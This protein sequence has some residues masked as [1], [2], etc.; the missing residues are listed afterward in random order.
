[1]LNRS[2][3]DTKQSFWNSLARFTVLSIP[4]FLL[5]FS[6]IFSRLDRGLYDRALRFNIAVRP[7]PLNPR[8]IRVDLNDSSERELEEAINSRAAFADLVSV[9]ADCGTD[10]AF[11]FVFRGKSPHD[12]AIAAASQWMNHFVLA[13]VPV[14]K[15]NGSLAYTNMSED[16]TRLLQKQLWHIKEDGKGTIPEAAGFILPSREITEAAILGHIGVEHD[17]DGLYR[18][19]PLFY[20]W[21][22]GLVPAFA[23]AMAAAELGIDPAD[24]E[25]Y[26]GKEL[27]L[28]SDP[29]IRIPV[30]SSAYVM[31]PYTA[32]WANDSYRLSFAR[33]TSAVH[34]EAV[35]DE[36]SQELTGAIVLVAD[37]TTAKKDYGITPF[38]TLYPLSGIHASL[39]SGILN[40]YFY[41]PPSRVLQAS[42]LISAFLAAFFFCLLKKDFFFH[43]SFLTLLVCCF[44]LAALLWT[45]ARIVPCISLVLVFITFQWAL[46]FVI[47]LA[48]RYH[49][50]FL[51]ELSFSRY[52]SPVVIGELIKDPSKLSLGGEEREMSALFTDI[53][54]FSTISEKIGDP[55]RLVDL[56]NFYLGTMS[57]IVLDN[58]GTIDKYEG[59]AIIAFFGAPLATGRD[60]ADACR[61]AILIK[62]REKTLNEEI[63]RRNLSPL[64]LFTRAGVNSGKMVVG[65]MGTE[66]K[67]DYT[68]MGNAVNLAS[69]LEGINKQYHT[70][71]LIGEQTRSRIGDDFVLR[72]L[73]RVRAIG[74]DTPVR[75]YELLDLHGDAAPPL[76]EMIA[77]W[78][79]AIGAFE[80]E[81]FEKGRKLFASI[82]GLNP[83]D[84]TAA[85]YA[86]RCESFIKNPP[87]RG[88]DAI[89][90][91]TEK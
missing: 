29:P 41:V 32:S 17:D 47:R 38:E 35:F 23:L 44:V 46:H 7:V 66:K 90:N 67:M 14:P 18:R 51:L 9:L 82:C 11:D 80:T 26:P 73:D 42:I 69:R 54:G 20:R 1:M 30:D 45:R 39:L 50:K 19:T 76:L 28:P 55:R 53:Q 56:L 34:D 88:W 22:D 62:R 48:A 72:R 68:V 43:L 2:L 12:K 91:L 71:I 83:G 10:A 36:L 74:F 24:I 70:G 87:P 13:A 59:D 31:I 85:L 78:E 6:G 3:L 4:V 61:T 81:A 60:A 63:I 27:V 15:E 79:E 33:V 75:I 84:L 64:P 21:K 25:F 89:N 40:N 5:G 77:V 49:E 86:K 37:I 65:N 52:L 58:R 57:D 8:I 16:E